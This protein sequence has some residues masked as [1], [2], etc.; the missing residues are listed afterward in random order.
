[1]KRT[2]RGFL[3]FFCAFFFGIMVTVPATLANASEP[4]EQQLLVD[5]AR[6]TFQSM[7][8]DYGMKWLRDNL[9]Q[10]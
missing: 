9:Y 6:V 1:M 10:A 3:L 5:Q 8:S 4:T 2:R 7:L